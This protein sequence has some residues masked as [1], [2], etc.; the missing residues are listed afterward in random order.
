MLRVRKDDEGPEAG[1]DREG[2]RASCPGTRGLARLSNRLQNHWMQLD[3]R[4]VLPSCELRRIGPGIAPHWHY[5]SAIE[6]N[7]V[8]GGGGAYY[9]EQAHYDLSPGVLVWMAPNQSHKLLASPD[10]QMWVL[11]LS[12][13]QLSRQMLDDIAGHPWRLLGREDA[14]ALARLFEHVSQDSDEPQLY[15]SGLQYAVHSALSLSMAGA[16]APQAPPHPAVLQALRI[17]REVPD[18]P[19]AAALAR[20][21]GVSSSYLGELLVEH[22]GRGFVAWR[23]RFRLERFQ[24]LYPET[25]DLLTAALDAGF[26]SYV[27]FHRVFTEIVG[28]TP[29]EWAKGSIESGSAPPI[30]DFAS[31]PAHGSS[32]MLWYD[33]ADLVLDDIRRWIA[34]N[35]AAALEVAEPSDDPPSVPTHV[36]ASYDQRHHLQSIMRDV[37]AHDPEIARKLEVI[38][39][40][41]DPFAL[42]ADQISQWGGYRLTDFAPII[43]IHILM[44]WWVI[45]G[46]QP[47][48]ASVS[49][50]IARV[51]A[52]LHASGSFVDA[53]VEDRQKAAAALCLQT[54]LFRQAAVGTVNSQK[55][56]AVDRLRAAAKLV[57]R[58]TYGLEPQA[59]LV[60]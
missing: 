36:V 46:R 5:H 35:F 23:N 2:S 54:F 17:L 4:H 60:Q 13:E 24:I 28:T 19:N 38:M 1:R 29:G 26:G 31:A 27:Q 25:E 52:A 22:T 41:F 49:A 48:Q 55:P 11:N 58:N 43:G 53:G 18:I 30:A 3:C 45:H 20:R 57:M 16:A 37:E 39:A 10:L 7:L 59:N 21:C 34:P 51:A 15:R 6:L 9:L 32:R 56:E 40:R 8:I 50:L 44:A 14:M 47:S 33:V 42:N 12:S